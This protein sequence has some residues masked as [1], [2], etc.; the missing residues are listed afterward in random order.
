MKYFKPNNTVGSRLIES[1]EPIGTEEDLLKK[2]HENARMMQKDKLGKIFSPLNKAEGNAL[3]N[4][5][6]KIK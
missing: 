6:S 1:P 5:T 3:K 4:K 2:K